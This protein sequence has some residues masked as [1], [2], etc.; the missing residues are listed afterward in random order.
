MKPLYTILFLAVCCCCN[1]QLLISPEVGFQVSRV[2][3][4]THG[5]NVENQLAPRI[6]INGYAELNR[7]SG[8]SVG[9]FATQF[10][11]KYD[12]FSTLQT[13]VYNSIEVPAAFNY[14]F[15]AHRKKVGFFVG[16]T[17]GYFLSG[18]RI[19]EDV[20]NANGKDTKQENKLVRKRDY[21]SIQAYATAG[22]IVDFENGF[23]T[24]L[25]ANYGV[26]SLSPK[27]TIHP[28]TVSVTAG[29][30]LNY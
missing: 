27:S 22:G 28:I 7:N 19:Y 6:G 11:R 10:R 14:L 4:K 26:L 30:Y 3:D 9:V 1:A 23:Y 15:D 8:I 16:A 12:F 21:K 25:T 17:G 29:F 20:K 13:F 2:T 5:A 18:K 24:K